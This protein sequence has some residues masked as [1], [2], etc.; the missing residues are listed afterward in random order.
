MYEDFILSSHSLIISMMFALYF[1]SHSFQPWTSGSNSC[2][3]LF[4]K[5]RGFTRGKSDLCLIDMVDLAGRVQ[6]LDENA[7]DS[8]AQRHA[9]IEKRS[10]HNGNSFN[11]RGER[12]SFQAC[13]S[14][15]TFTGNGER[16]R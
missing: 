9:N 2:K 5:L 10:E 13:V 16:V 11:S 3:E 15:N 14:T 1:P 7:R 4:S 12:I 8:A 6:K